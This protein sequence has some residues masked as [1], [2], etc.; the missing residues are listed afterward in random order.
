MTE[1]TERESRSGSSRVVEGGT[2]R[3]GRSGDQL[4]PRI[5]RN[6]VCERNVGALTGNVLC[7]AHDGGEDGVALVRW[8][9]RTLLRSTDRAIV[10]VHVAPGHSPAA[11]AAAF[12]TERNAERNTTRSPGGAS[13][14]TRCCVR[15][16]TWRA[17]SRR[18]AASAR[19]RRRRPR[20]PCSWPVRGGAGTRR[21]AGSSPLGARHRDA[22]VVAESRWKKGLG[23]FLPPGSAEGGFHEKWGLG[24]LLRAASERSADVFVVGSRRLKRRIVSGGAARACAPGSRPCALR[25]RPRAD[26]LAPLRRN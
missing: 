11:L 17:P 21:N 5:P 25:W 4:V 9:L 8:T 18:S 1:T 2:V 20:A 15:T 10:V 26:A 13:S 7:V 3:A 22:R 14:P 12:G 24:A 6:P 16:R 19:R 23:P